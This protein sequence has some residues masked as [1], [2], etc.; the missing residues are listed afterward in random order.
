MSTTAAAAPLTFTH[1]ELRDLGNLRT[2]EAMLTVQRNRA[3]I[4]QHERVPPLDAALFAVQ[5]QIRAAEQLRQLRL[6]ERAQ[7]APTAVLGNPGCEPTRLHAG[8]QPTLALTQVGG[9]R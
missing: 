8:Y 6:A 5:E 7:F 4:E 2:A 1:L 9:F 3:A